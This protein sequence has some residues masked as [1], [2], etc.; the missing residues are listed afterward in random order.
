LT[1]KVT[2]FEDPPASD[3]ELDELVAQLRDTAGRLVQRMRNPP[4]EAG[5]L[6]RIAQAGYL[7]DVVVS[8]LPF[9]PIDKQDILEAF[10]PT[11]RVRKALG[12][13]SRELVQLPERRA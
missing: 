8:H 3:A 7:A 5:A 9:E 4:F 6:A 11:V 13:V 12:M 1:A 2:T 10:D